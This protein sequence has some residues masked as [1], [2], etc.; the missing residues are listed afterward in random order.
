[1]TALEE[2]RRH[3]GLLDALVPARTVSATGRLA[4][5]PDPDE[6]VPR[7]QT[8]LS[9]AFQKVGETTRRGV[10][11]TGVI[12]NGAL[13]LEKLRRVQPEGSEALSL[14]LYRRMPLA[15]LWGAGQTAS[16][17]GQ[18]FPTGGAGEAINLVNARY[19]SQAGIKAYSH[20][21]DQFAPFAVQTIP[22]TVSEAP[23]ISWTVCR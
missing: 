7:R 22:V 2:S 19:G 15:R 16:S 17:D 10:L 20:V 8:A 12:D 14:D 4:V 13:R 21:S 6:W 9:E 3:R 23:Y 11:P 5:P 18:F 1:M